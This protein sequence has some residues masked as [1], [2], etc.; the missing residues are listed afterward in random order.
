MVVFVI[1]LFIGAFI[2]FILA[3]ILAMSRHSDQYARRKHYQRGLESW[4]DLY[5]GRLELLWDR[6]SSKVIN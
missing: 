1:G 4:V 6:G 5:E 3:A 2:G